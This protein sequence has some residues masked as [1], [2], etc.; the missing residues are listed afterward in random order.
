[1][2]VGNAAGESHPLIGEGISMALQSSALLVDMLTQRRC[3]PIDVAAALHQQVVYQAAW[4]AAFAPRLRLAALY[5][6]VAMRPALARP[7]LGVLRRWP[8]L[9]TH[10]AGWAGKASESSQNPTF[11]EETP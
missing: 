10:A 2:P 4:R 11:I 5:A 7:A 1:M 9:L 8:T 6:Q 3:A